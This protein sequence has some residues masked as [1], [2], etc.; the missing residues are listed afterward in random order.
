TVGKGER[1]EIPL[2]GKPVAA[3]VKVVV[4]DNHGNADFTEIAELDLFGERAAPPRTAKIE[5]DYAATYGALRFVQDG[6]EVYGCYDHD[7]GVVW[8]S[9]VGRVARVT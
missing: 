8:G 6:D 1:K 7:G 3:R 9:M 5:G 4:V 2:P